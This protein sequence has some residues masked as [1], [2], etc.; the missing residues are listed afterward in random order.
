[1]RE[2]VEVCFSIKQDENGFPPVSCERIWCLPGEDDLLVVDNIP[3]Y[4]RDVSMGDEVKTEIREGSRWFSSLI[5]P[6]TNTTL[7]VSV[8]NKIIAPLVIPKLQALGGLT[9]KMEG[10]DFNCRIAPAFRR[11]CRDF[12]LLGPRVK[13]WQLGL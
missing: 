3:F 1:M 9:E 5:K 6:S 12:R 2:P 13:R 7:R 8:R 10:S 4:A 11:C